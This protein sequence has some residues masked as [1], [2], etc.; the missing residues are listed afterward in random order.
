[1]PSKTD[2]VFLAV[3]VHV[4]V[5]I[6]IHVVVMTNS[7]KNVLLRGCWQSRGLFSD[8]LA[9]RFLQM[10]VEMAGDVGPEY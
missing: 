10:N 9:T 3:S 2:I 6:Y 4:S 8:F 7:C 5:C 1:M